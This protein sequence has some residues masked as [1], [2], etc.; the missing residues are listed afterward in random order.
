MTLSLGVWGWPCRTILRQKGPV[1]RFTVVYRGVGIETDNLNW[2]KERRMFHKNWSQGLLAVFAL[3]L[4]GAPA[5]ADDPVTS[6]TAITEVRGDG[7]KVSAVAVEY[8]KVIDSARLKLTDFTVAGA[9]VAKIYS[10]T[11]AAKAVQPTNGTFVIVELVNTVQ[12]PVM[13]PPPGGAPAG[14]PP[15]GGPSGGGGPKLGQQAQDASSSSPLTAQVTQVGT[16]T[17]VSG[18]S[19]PGGKSWKSTKTVNL[20]V[21]DF[22]QAVFTDPRYPGQPLTYNLFVPKDYNPSRKYP[23]VLFMHDSGVISHDP[24]KTLTQG[25]GAVAFA[26]PEAQAKNA[27]FVLAPQYDRVIADDSSQ[28]TDQVDITIDL[29]KSLTAQYSIDTDRLYNTGQSMGG[30]VSL[31]MD[32]RYPTVFAASLL[33]ACQWDATQVAPL[34]SKPLWFVVSEGDVKANPGQAAILAAL[35]PLGATV[36]Q[37][38]WSAEAPAAEIQ[39]KVAALAAQPAQIHQATYQGGSHQYTWLYAYGTDGFREWLFRQAKTEGYS[40]AELLSRAQS[41]TQAG[42]PVGALPY[43]TKAASSGD[44]RA[45]E[46][47][48]E[49]YSSGSGAATDY[50]KAA[51]AFRAAIA[52]GSARSMTNLGILYL[53]GTGVAQSTSTAL[54]WFEKAAAAGDMK[55]P[56]WAGRVYLEGSSE[57]PANPAKALEAFNL[58]A[59]RGDVTANYY[60]GYLYENGIAVARNYPKAAEFYTKAA[61]TTGHAEGAACFALGRLYEKGL[62]VTADKNKALAWYKRG[63]ELGD[64]DSRAAVQRMSKG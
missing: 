16:L 44:V 5:F 13:G 10:N 6:I 23:L 27:A 56:R 57:V 9:T 34:R 47:L 59:G 63:A 29:L 17:T 20:V 19:I 26:T 35:K 12:A 22:R 21:E 39:T 18:E 43:L 61:P 58:A 53:N 31:A 48:G 62:G 11:T 37:A 7:Q 50:A 55:G 38:T 3:G 36:A 4:A 1:F 24:T 2:M 54:L 49:A 52:L 32:I 25:N 41:L 14:G 46:M 40:T 15:A 60:L 33:V 45:N 42:D 51:E 8:K 28:T 30:M 64:A